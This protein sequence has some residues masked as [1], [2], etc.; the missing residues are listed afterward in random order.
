MDSCGV[1]QRLN[2]Y[3]VSLEV[4][5]EDELHRV[6]CIA[7]EMPSYYRIYIDEKPDAIWADDCQYEVEILFEDERDVTV[8]NL[9]L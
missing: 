1:G 4:A 3:S 5:N 6:R 8:F 7:L 2:Y 9:K